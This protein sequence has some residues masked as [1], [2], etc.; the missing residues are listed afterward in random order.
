[1]LIMSGT[2]VCVR[3]CCVF[4][5]SCTDLKESLYIILVLLTIGTIC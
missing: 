2:S 5:V 4:S 3:F 1:M